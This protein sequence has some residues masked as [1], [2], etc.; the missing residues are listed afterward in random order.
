MANEIVSNEILVKYNSKIIARANSFSLDINKETIDV[1]SLDP[2]GWRRII[3]GMKSWSASSDSIVTRGSVAGE[4]N[5]HDLMLELFNN[6]VPVELIITSAVVGD[7][8]YKG[9][10]IITSLS[11]SGSVGETITYSVSFDGDGPIT[12]AT[13][14]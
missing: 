6:D 14:A 7:Q 2:A 10:V 11:Q 12:Q 4:V 13:V 9:N 5:Y 8:Y 1:T 3:G